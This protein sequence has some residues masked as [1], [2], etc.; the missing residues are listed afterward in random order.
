MLY[1][2]FPGH[3]QHVFRLAIPLTTNKDMRYPFWEVCLQYYLCSTCR[4]HI[5]VLYLCMAFHRVCNQ[6]NTMGATSEAGTAYRSGAPE[7]TRGFSS[8]SIFSFLCCVFV[9]VDHCLSFCPFTFSHC[10]VC[11]SSIYGFRLPLWY[12]KKTPQILNLVRATR[13]QNNQNRNIILNLLSKLTLTKPLSCLKRAVT[14]PLSCVKRPQTRQLSCA[15]RAEI[16][17]LYYAKRPLT[18]PL[19][20]VQWPLI[21]SLSC[22]KPV[23]TNRYSV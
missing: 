22:V 17:P 14:N 10:V 6:S 12:I 9:V 8:C 3:Q 15:K 13:F 18:K 19:S 21:K 4:K 11:L 5:V 7:F 16:K 2:N 1:V 20:C 23:V